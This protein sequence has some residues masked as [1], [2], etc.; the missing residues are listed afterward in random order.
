VS[1]APKVSAARVV[2][3]PG[4]ASSGP[5]D[6]GRRRACAGFTL[7]ELLVALAVIGLGIGAVAMLATAVLG[8]FSTES[9]AAEVQ[10]RA[11]AGLHVLVED[12]RDAGMG[13]LQLPSEAPGG[14]VPALAPDVWTPSVWG[15]GASSGVVGVWRAPRDASQARLA[16]GVAPRESRLRL[17]RP[18]FCPPSSS[19]C[20]FA[21]GDALMIYTTQG[22]VETATVRQVLAPLELD[23]VAPVSDAWPAGAAV[24]AVIAH[25]YEPRGDPATGLLQ[26]VR[27]RGGGPATPVIDFVTRFDVEW[28]SD[29]G[30]PT[31]V[32]GAGGGEY[33]TTGPTPPPVAVVD[34]VAWP[35]GENC[36]FARDAAG[37]ATWRG[38]AAGASPAAIPLTALAD[39]PWCPAPGAPTRWDADLMRVTSVRV[40]LGIAAADASL[41][42]HSGLGLRRGPGMRSVPDFV[43]ELLVRRGRHGAGG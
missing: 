43:V 1:A 16:I 9:V 37:V 8:A 10:Q 5:C 21:A 4:R 42:P 17:V 18:Q 29:G 6:R 19:T 33:A 39:G 11:R 23:L 41:R 7:V 35:A 32:V 2:T 27:R 15:V 20:G 13:F 34:H 25:S 28:W 30:T 14:G 31:V 24:S 26:L 36:A 3:T 22:R 40:R 38:A 12:V